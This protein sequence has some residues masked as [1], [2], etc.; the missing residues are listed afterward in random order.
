LQLPILAAL[1]VQKAKPGFSDREE[2]AQDLVARS[3][4]LPDQTG[5]GDLD[6]SGPA[7]RVADKARAHYGALSLGICVVLGLL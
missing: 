7:D 2:V 6:P 3:W 4:R 5:G 1:V